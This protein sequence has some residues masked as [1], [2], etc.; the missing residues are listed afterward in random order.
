MLEMKQA[1][2]HNPPPP[3]TSLFYLPSINDAYI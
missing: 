1:D 2:G 3:L